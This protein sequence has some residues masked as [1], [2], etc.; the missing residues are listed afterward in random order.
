MTK[1]YATDGNSVLDHLVSHIS[2]DAFTSSNLNSPNHPIN[3][4]VNATSETLTEPPMTT[5]QAPPLNFVAP[6]QVNPN[7]TITSEPPTQTSIPESPPQN[8]EIPQP[9]PLTP[10]PEHSEQPQTPPS[11]K[12]DDNPTDNQEHH[13]PTSPIPA[14]TQNIDTPP[15]SP[16]IY[17]PIYK[18]M[19]IEEL[20]LPI[21]IALPILE[22]KLK[23]D[24]NIDDDLITISPRPFIDLSKIKIIPLKRKQPE[25]II[26]FNKDHPFFNPNSEP[27]LELLDNAISI[28][29]KRFKGM[30]E[31]VL[32]FPS[33]I[34]ARIRELEDKFSQSLR[35]LGGHL[36]KK[37]QGRGMSALNQIMSAEE[38]FHAPRLTFYNHE[39]ECQRLA[40]IAVVT[41]SIRT[42]CETAKRLA[43]EEAAYSRMVIDAEQARIA[44]EAEIQRLAD[45]E[46]LKVLVARA[47][48]IAEVEAQKIA[49]E[50]EMGSHLSEDAIMQD[51]DSDEQTSDKGKKVIVD[52]SPPRSPVKLITGSSSSDIPPAVQAALDEMRNEMKNE[53]AEL[54]E[55]MKHEI[56]ELRA[57]V[58]A[59]L[60]ASGEATHKKIDEMMSF[61]HS[62]ANQMKKP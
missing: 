52:P 26:P 60:N 39:E 13:I 35:L 9:E 17:G 5:V 19:T 32:I 55:E 48:R 45:E 24:I 14:E 34:D 59:D 43:E 16:L 11:D 46:A 6:E 21:N 1:E 40:I 7:T 53:I 12:C 23:Q 3:K 58:R 31:E 57:D 44:A 61:L 27:N 25:P 10:Q 37:I 20:S 56:D 2:D 15:S 47:L 8:V 41:E 30:E 33:D 54:K 28:S 22:T 38:L 50:Q 36:K 51:Q 4:F 49:N 42:S 29:L 62:L 18:P